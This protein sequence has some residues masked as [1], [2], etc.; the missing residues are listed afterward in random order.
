[1][2]SDEARARPSEL[3]DFA[4]PWGVWIAATLRLSD[5]IE[6]GATR[7]EDLA[8]RAGADPD[9]LGRLLRYLV[10]RGV[11]AETGSGYCEH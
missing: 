10:A 3:T 2:S 1:V 4:A 5:H 11:F 6:A 8:E 9:S 7:L